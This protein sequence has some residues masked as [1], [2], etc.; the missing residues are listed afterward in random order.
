M[1]PLDGAAKSELE[2][3]VPTLGTL[4]FLAR[5][6]CRRDRANAFK[7]LLLKKSNVGQGD[8]NAHTFIGRTVT[9]LLI[10]WWSFLDMFP[11]VGIIVRVRICALICIDSFILNRILLHCLKRRW[12]FASLQTLTETSVKWLWKMTVGCCMWLSDVFRDFLA[13]GQVTKWSAIKNAIN[14]VWRLGTS[15]IGFRVDPQWKPGRSWS[16]PVITALHSSH[17]KRHVAQGLRPVWLNDFE[18]AQIEQ[19]THDIPQTSPKTSK[20]PWHDAQMCEVCLLSVA[21]G[22]WPQKRPNTS[23]QTGQTTQL[24]PVRWPSGPPHPHWSPKGLN[25]VWKILKPTKTTWSHGCRSILD[26]WPTP[27]TPS[28]I[29]HI[30]VR[31][32]APLRRAPGAMGAGRSAAG[33][34]AGF[35]AQGLPEALYWRPQ[36]QWIQLEAFNDL[37]GYRGKEAVKWWFY[38]MVA[39]RWFNDGEICVALPQ[40]LLEFWETL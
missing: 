20:Q 11:G 32:A 40:W 28:H 34:P 12:W 38:S 4:L 18:T 16:H 5:E 23:H 21:V 24:P 33:P 29:A 27:G 14:A 15:K 26:L 8:R 17:W 31:R 13:F 2:W 19:N 1:F 35:F 30:F 37:R 3:S 10:Y 36:G 25:Y 9:C 6:T 39:K 22:V 7:C